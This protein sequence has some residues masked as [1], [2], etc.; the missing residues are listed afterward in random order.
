MPAQLI[1][2]VEKARCTT[3]NRTMSPGEKAWIPGWKQLVHDG[4][5]TPEDPR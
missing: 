1:T 2:I 3:C 5:H 4:C